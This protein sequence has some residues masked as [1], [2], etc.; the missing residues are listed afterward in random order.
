MGDST[1]R[2]DLKAWEEH[3]QC[4]ETNLD[5]AQVFQRRNEEG[6]YICQPWEQS[7]NLTKCGYPPIIDV[8]DCPSGGAAFRYFYK[9]Y[10]WTPLDQWY[11]SQQQHLFRDID[12]LVISL[13]RWF[14]YY[15]STEPLS[16][17]NQM[18][19]FLVELRKVYSGIILYHSEYTEHLVRT[20]D[21]SPA[22]CTPHAICGDCGGEDK[23]ECAQTETAERPQRDV[24]MRSVMERHQILYLDRWNTSKSLPL[25]YYQDWYCNQETFNQWFCSHHLGF[26]A[27]QHMRLIAIA[28]KNLFTSLLVEN[29][30]VE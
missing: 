20:V 13:G 11:L 29:G 2:A 24:E 30:F 3:Y 21:K 18:E 27:L 22:Q 16:V 25:E 9:I 12:V 26:V 10:P 5:E 6:D 14:V 17:T 4:N 15:Q 7:I 28:I 8:A 19:T 23:W 1:T